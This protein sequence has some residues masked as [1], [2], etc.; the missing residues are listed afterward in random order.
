MSVHT[1]DAGVGDLANSKAVS[2]IMISNRTDEVVRTALAS[3]VAQTHRPIEIVFFGN[4]A[5]LE[6]P[7]L[8]V[9]T[10]DVTVVSGHSPGNLGVAGGRNAAVALSTGPYVF[11]VDDDAVLEPDTLAAAMAAIGDPGVGAV[12]CRIVDPDSGETAL[13]FQPGDPTTESKAAFDIDMVIGCGNLVRRDLFDQLG[14][15]WD[16]YFREMEEID[17]SWRLLDAGWRIRYEPSAVVR[18]PER[19]RRIY[20]YAVPSNVALLFRLF[21]A[22]YAIRE[23]VLKLAIFAV[24]AV[25]HRELD[26]FFAGLKATPAT[27]RRALGERAPLSKATRDHLRQLHGRR[28]RWRRS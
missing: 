10:S 18:H 11:F 4:G 17:F 20:R 22:G 5:Q 8:P 15:L 13:W 12:A 19:D 27:V 16:G 24:R 2:V 1:A 25:R 9:G 28:N 26:E 6:L 14:G 21:P 23:S 3:V 7:T